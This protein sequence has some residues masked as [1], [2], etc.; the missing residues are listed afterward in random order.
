MNEGYD[1]YMFK[2]GLM[3]IDLPY[4]K[5]L[6]AEYGIILQNYSKTFCKLEMINSQNEINESDGL[7]SDG[8]CFVS[9][10]STVQCTGGICYTVEIEWANPREFFNP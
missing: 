6:E 1:T 9:T 8:T 7:V 10:S 2:G 3:R 4:F 5:Y